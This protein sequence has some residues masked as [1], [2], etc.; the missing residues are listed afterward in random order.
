VLP[1]SLGSV[2]GLSGSRLR[3]TVTEATVGHPRQLRQQVGDL[4]KVV[5]RLPFCRALCPPNGGC[6]MMGLLRDERGALIA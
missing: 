4:L 1:N 3:F 2:E 5:N 6:K